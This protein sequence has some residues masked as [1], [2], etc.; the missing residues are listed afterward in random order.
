[1]AG[2]DQ[3]HRNSVAGKDVEQPNAIGSPGRAGERENDRILSQRPLRLGVGERTGCLGGGAGGEDEEDGNDGG[4]G[5]RLLSFGIGLSV[6]FL[7]VII[8]PD[9]PA[10]T[11]IQSRSSRRSW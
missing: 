7:S 2:D 1:M 3:P 10:R 4:S 8:K 5:R 6:L 9:P 11:Q